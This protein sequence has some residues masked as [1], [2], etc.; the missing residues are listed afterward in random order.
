MYW[1]KLKK[2]KVA[3]KLA[4]AAGAIDTAVVDNA[5]LDK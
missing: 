1:F 2:I 4:T 3:K 5:T